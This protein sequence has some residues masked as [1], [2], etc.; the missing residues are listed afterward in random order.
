MIYPASYADTEEAPHGKQY[1]LW[2][3][4]A[5]YGGPFLE[6]LERKFRLRLK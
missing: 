6:Y 5:A 4:N 2:I 1:Q 3:L